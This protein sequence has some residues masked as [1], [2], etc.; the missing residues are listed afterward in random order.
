MTISAAD[1]FRLLFVL[2]GT[3]YSIDGLA[4]TQEFKPVC[5]Y[6]MHSPKTQTFVNECKMRESGA[7]IRHAGSCSDKNPPASNS[8]PT[9]K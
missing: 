7:K 1:L 2:A 5:G 8:K 4:C 9:T 3:I 6:W